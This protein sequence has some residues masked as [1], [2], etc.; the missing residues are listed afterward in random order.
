MP[1]SA[2]SACRRASAGPIVAAF[3][4]VTT[5]ARA[6]RPLADG[7][8][9]PAVDLIGQHR[10]RPACKMEEEL[11]VPLRPREPGVY[12]RENSGPQTHRC[13]GD[14]LERPP[15]DRRVAH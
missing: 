15:V 10:V 12:D 1:A 14:G 2:A 3:P 4:C 11:P 13:L 6:T 7:I 5:A 8:V 9:D